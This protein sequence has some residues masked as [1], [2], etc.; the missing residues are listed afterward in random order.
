[1]S[2]VNDSLRRSIFSEALEKRLY[3]DAEQMILRRSD[4]CLNLSLDVSRLHSDTKKKL[5]ET[6]LNLVE[7]NTWEPNTFNY[8]CDPEGL[9]EMATIK[10]DDAPKCFM[11]ID[12]I[13]SYE[14]E[15]YPDD[16]SKECVRVITLATSDEY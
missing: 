4:A 9:H 1:M 15:R 5:L 16:I 8:A 7:S 2:D 10:I 11:K 14:E 3:E 12:Y 6:C 13:Q